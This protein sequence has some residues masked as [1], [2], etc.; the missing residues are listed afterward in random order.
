MGR[1]Q[2][3]LVPV[4]G[5]P[6]SL[7]ALDH[8]VALASDYGA[9]LDVLHVLQSRDPLARDARVE[10]ERETESA[11][12]RARH[13][14]GTRVHLTTVVGE[15]TRA[16]IDAARQGVDM[17]VMGTHGH[18]G[19]LHALLGSV[20]EGVVRNAPCPVLTVR[21]AGTGYQT[22]AEQR[23]GRPSLGDQPPR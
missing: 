23:H 8:A 21:V 5:S 4:D 18:V 16:I 2:T 6:P 10:A 11:V 15:V 19:R 17:I 1:L 3:I 7:A 20:T 12:E 14:L 9:R 22:F 13:T